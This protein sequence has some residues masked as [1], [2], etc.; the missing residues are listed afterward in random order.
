MFTLTFVG[1]H[2]SSCAAHPIHFCAYSIGGRAAYGANRCPLSQA[3]Y[4]EYTF[5]SRMLINTLAVPE[6]RFQSSKEVLWNRDMFSLLFESFPLRRKVICGAGPFKPRHPLLLSLPLGILGE[7]HQGLCDGYIVKGC[8]YLP[9][10][11]IREK[12]TLINDVQ[13]KLNLW[14]EWF[15]QMGCI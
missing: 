1:Q 15:S 11:C 13:G 6:G 8:I 4:Q 9:G 12:Q 3:Q 14:N 7:L 2:L 10:K 5:Y